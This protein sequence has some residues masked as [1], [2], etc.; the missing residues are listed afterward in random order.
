M[1]FNFEKILF[2]AVLITG[3][4]ALF[5][6]LFLEKKRK[7]RH[8]HKQPLIIEYSRSFFPVLLVVFLLRSFL[9]EPFRIPTGSLEPSLRIGDF[10][11]VNKFDYGIRLPL[12]HTQITKANLPQHG[13]IFVFRYPPDQRYDFIK[14]VVGMPGDRISYVNKELTI[15]GQKIPQTF[16]EE[17]TRIDE[18]GNKREVVIKEENLLGVK[19]L[20]YQDPLQPS[21]DFENIVVPK[22]MY[23]AMGDNRDDS[24]DS[25]FWGFVPE[26]NLVGKAVVV[27]MS[28]DSQDHTVRWNRLFKPV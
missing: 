24:A 4:I 8:K 22:G 16:K 18:L 26:A 20:I 19:H 3:V 2:W 25:R 23:F 27:W 15:N 9:Y 7:A 14:R 10:V 11:L 17:T 12:I 6:I 1:N 13:D 5:D 21:D 28:W